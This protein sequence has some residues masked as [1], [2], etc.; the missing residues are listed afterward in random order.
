[1]VQ[2]SIFDYMEFPVRFSFYKGLGIIDH[3][4]KIFKTEAE[5]ENYLKDLNV[6]SRKKSRVNNNLEIIVI[7][8]TEE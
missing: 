3:V 8:D 1:M 4:N 7:W 2:T 6:F 5:K